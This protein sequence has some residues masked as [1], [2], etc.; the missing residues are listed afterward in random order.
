[1]QTCRRKT[2][3]SRRRSISRYAKPSG[4]AQS[5]Y[6]SGTTRKTAAGVAGSMDFPHLM[7]GARR[8][9]A[10]VSVAVRSYFFDMVAAA[11]DDGAVAIVVRGLR[12]HSRRAAANLETV[13]C[14][15]TGCDAGDFVAVA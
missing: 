15:V 2:R 11:A 3:L 5:L 9:D 7:A 12:G 13:A 14:I 1:P 8:N 10:G 6:G 4:E